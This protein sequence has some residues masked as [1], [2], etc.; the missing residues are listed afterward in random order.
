MWDWTWLQLYH[1][2]CKHCWHPI[3]PSWNI[4]H[5]EIFTHFA[6]KGAATSWP[7]VYA[8]Q[9]RDGKLLHQVSSLERQHKT[10]SWNVAPVV[11]RGV[12]IELFPHLNMVSPFLCM[13]NVSPGYPHPG[14]WEDTHHPNTWLPRVCSHTHFLVKWGTQGDRDDLGDV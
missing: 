6:D 8:G 1:T 14:F 7:W 13:G 5:R 10:W 2:R 12:W 3:L 9:G 4:S 11:E